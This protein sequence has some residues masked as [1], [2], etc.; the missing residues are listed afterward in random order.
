MNKKF[1]TVIVATCLQLSAV[2]QSIY[3]ISIRSIT[4]D[5]IAISQCAGKKLLITIL[6]LDQQGD[7]YQQ[8][9]AF[10]ARYAD[11]IQV[12]GIPA[13]ESGYEPGKDTSLRQLY[14]NTGIILAE[15]MHVLKSAGSLQSTLM[16]WLTDATRNHYANVNNPGVGHKF[17]ISESGK[18]YAVFSAQTS[19]GSVIV[20]RVVHDN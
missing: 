9:I 19:L 17:F 13:F 1:F 10:K 12:I 14:D 3:D 8:L 11:S 20:D 2:A 5:P 6:P 7:G 16:R 4:G 15:G 18:L